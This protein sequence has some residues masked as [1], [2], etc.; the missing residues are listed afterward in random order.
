M[1]PWFARGGWSMTLYAAWRLEEYQSPFDPLIEPLTAEPVST[2][3]K[4][5]IPSNGWL[6]DHVFTGDR[7]V[8]IFGQI[9][10]PVHLE[11][12]DKWAAI[13]QS[14]GT[15][16]ITYGIVGNLDQQKALHILR[17]KACAENYTVIGIDWRAHGTTAM[18][19]PALTSD[20][21]H[22]GKDFVHIAA[23]AKALG[24][25]PPYWF[26]G[27]SLGGQL[28]LWGVHSDSLTLAEDLG[29]APTD[30]G[31]AAV[32]CP[33]LDANRSLDFLGRS[34]PGRML[35]QSITQKLKAL[36]KQIHDCHPGHLNDEAIARADS[37]RHFDEEFVIHRL[38]F[39]SV[40]EYYTAS[41]PLPWL[42]EITKPVFMLYAADDPM[43]HPDIV[44]DLITETQHNPLIDLWVTQYGGHVG[45]FS[46]TTCQQEWGDR[47]PWWAW[48]RTIDWLKAKTAQSA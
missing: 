47:D 14:I 41:S 22:E 25:P 44:P 10:S 37:I 7:H 15:I 8:P 31:G 36:A 28:A 48:N 13:T 21:L 32:V 24:C 4:P 29:L 17:D 20:G 46:G 12:S 33:N 5:S 16:I 26:L 30:I 2:F 18:L 11:A 39:D 34:L 9:S 19:S 23:Q 40:E 43:F 3:S 45:Y 38:G 42:S 27:Y 6:I 35:E 1:P